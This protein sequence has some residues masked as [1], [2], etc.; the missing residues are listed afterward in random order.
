MQ[1][2]SSMSR[3]QRLSAVGRELLGAALTDGSSSSGA[4]QGLSVSARK[5]LN[6][7]LRI[8]GWLLKKG[9]G[10]SIIGRRTW[11]ERFCMLD[12]DTC[13]LSWYVDEAGAQMEQVKGSVHIAGAQVEV[14]PFGE[15]EGESKYE[16]HLRVT[17]K[18]ADG[19]VDRVF[20]MR[21]RS[22]A[23]LRAWKAVLEKAAENPTEQYE[24]YE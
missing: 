6:K 16:N 20:N 12:S 8:Q 7:P 11:K 2:T 4:G 3:Q 9:L 15:G 5:T 19:S 10:S 23:E 14:V 13:V 21:P 22:K 18:K 17:T 1:N 24:Q